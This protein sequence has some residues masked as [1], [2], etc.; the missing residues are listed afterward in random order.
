MALQRRISL[1]FFIGIFAAGSTAL[2]YYYYFVYEPP[3]AAAEKFLQDMQNQN[4]EGVRADIVMAVGTDSQGR[5]SANG[6]DMTFREPEEA[7]LKA[8]LG[9]DFKMGRILDQHVREGRTRNYFYLVYREPDGRVYALVVT[10]YD[11]RFRVVIPEA[12][13]A[14]KVHRYLWDYTWTN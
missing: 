14:S 12:P 2:G 6:T 5:P 7:D 10:M 13:Q 8:L 9:E 11:G 3:L 1:L 4:V